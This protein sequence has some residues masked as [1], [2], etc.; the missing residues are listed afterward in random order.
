MRPEHWLYTI[1]L[2]LRS[3]FRWAQADQELDDELR[4][5]LER[6]TGEY[7]AQ[8]MTRE[9]ARRRARLGL[10]GIEQTKEKCRDTRRVSWIQDFV[11]DLRFSL[12]M[13]RKSPGFTLVAVLTL[14]LG[15]GANNAIF[16]VL[17]GVVLKMLPVREPTRLV[18]LE[19][20]YQN[21]TFNFFSYASYVHLRDANRVF[22]DLFAWAN[23]PMNLGTHDEVEPIKG[24]FV[25]GNYFASLEVPA[26][27][28]RTILPSD[29]QSGST[30]VAVLSYS[31]WQSRFGADPQAIGQTIVV[32]RVPVTIVGVTP[33]SFFGTEVGRSFDVAIPVSLQPRLNPD[34]PFIARVDAQWLRV[35]ARLGPG[36]SR[37]QA[38]TQCTLLWPQILTEIDPKHIYGA[39]NFGIRLD[40][41]ST[42]LSQLRDE[43]SRPLFILLG[44]AGFVLL[45]ACFNVAN[46][47]SARARARQRELAVRFALGASRWRI[48]RQMLAECMLLCALGSASGLLLAFWGARALI[49]FLSVTGLHQVTLDISFDARVLLFATSIGLVALVASGVVP[50]LRAS[51]S[52]LGS[53]LR[54][55]QFLTGRTQRL[56]RGLVSAQV[57]LSLPLLLG[58]ALFIQSLQN[59]LAV[60]AGFNREG[61]LMAHIN[62][63]RAGYSGDQLASLYQQILERLETVPGVRAATLSTYPPLTGGGGT[64]FSASN[65]SIDSRRVPRTT[66]GNI[67]LNE[68]APDFFETLGIPFSSGRDFSRFDNAQ[69]RR[70]VIIS[71]A[72]ATQFFPHE[73]PVGHTIQVTETSDP[74]EI[75]G[76]VKTMKYETLRESPHYIV[77]E[78]YPQDIQN[79]GSVYVEVRTANLAGMTSLVRELV[80][81]MARQVPIDDSVTLNDWVNQFLV[82]DKLM[83]AFAGG[84]GV[85]ATLL[86]AVGLYGV[87][88]YAVSQRTREIA[89]RIAFGA[90]S[91]EVLRLILYDIVLFVL[92]GVAVGTPLALAL[93]RLLPHILFGLSPSDYGIMLRAV[94]ILIGTALAAA[95]I[96]AR[97]ATRVDP[98]VALRYE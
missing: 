52:G 43:Y 29:D 64:F 82:R 77:F 75:V 63:A 6:K 94:C 41:A 90:K 14:A 97:K 72:L 86:A 76:V 21:D 45:I 16:S 32:E 18:Q 8:G 81:G 31:S 96:P 85:L 87:V 79:S 34:R 1:P 88:A 84:F 37:Q 4:D 35:M 42:G 50:A 24:L 7:L 70:V 58:A 71:K 68:I 17:N 60:D 89:V 36:V 62:A 11:Q 25:T 30:P 27:I 69:A 3:L 47:L 67:Y 91:V 13:L 20:T 2:R 10:G 83:A 22:S 5:H 78:P 54:G 12:R 38:R 44:I 61:I 49:H 51:N 66:D 26:L 93:A 46:L 65:M 92:I 95:Y 74:A 19:Q 15:I 55:G 59:V 40:P 98:M 28:G 57:A 33:P 73:N 9:E 53:S 48:T 56:N 80:A 23:R 39:H